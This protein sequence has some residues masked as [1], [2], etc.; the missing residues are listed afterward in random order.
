[1]RRREFVTLVGG[2]AAA[3]PLAARA[4]QTGVRTVGFLGAT[5]HPVAMQWTAAFVERLQELGWTEGRTIII[6]YRW[7]DGSNAR[8]AEIAAEFVRL[9]VDVIV[10][11]ASAMVVAAKQATTTIPIVFAA[12]GDPLGTGL[13][14]SLARPGSNV[15]GLSLQ[16]TEIASKRLELLREAVPSLGRVGVLVNTGNPAAVLEMAEV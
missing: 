5:T 12:A 11:W 3:W 7:A 4:Q 15:T 9:K 10:T 16:Q 1:M 8:A 13:V 6:D 2:A 14:T